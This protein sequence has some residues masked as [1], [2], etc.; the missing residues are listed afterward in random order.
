MTN[1]TA[2]QFV[3]WRGPTDKPVNTAMHDLIFA[4]GRYGINNNVIDDPKHSGRWC[5]QRGRIGRSQML[6]LD[7]AAERGASK[8]A[9]LSV[10]TTR[11]TARSEIQFHVAL[12][13]DSGLA[14]DVG[15][16]R[17]QKAPSI[18]QF[19]SNHSRYVLYWTM[20]IDIYWT[21]YRTQLKSGPPV[22]RIWSVAWWPRVD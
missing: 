12:Y 15:V 9:L 7:S 17:W 16:R 3:R 20:Y 10:G 21:S 2:G 13:T 1:R 19:W 4:R 14:P 11:S 5:I 8:D 18:Y 6:Q 22:S